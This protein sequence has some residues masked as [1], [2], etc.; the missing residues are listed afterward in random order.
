MAGS[1]FTY[2]YTD[3]ICCDQQ[4]VKNFFFPWNS[5][6]RKTVLPVSPEGISLLIPLLNRY[7]PTLG[8]QFSRSKALSPGLA[9]QHFPAAPPPH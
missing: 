3:W 2:S 4:S 5:T 9:W 7:F 6:F 8:I 1:T